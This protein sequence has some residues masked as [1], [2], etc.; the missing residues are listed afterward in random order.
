MKNIPIPSRPC[1]VVCLLPVPINTIKDGIVYLF[2]AVDVES[3]FVFGADAERGDDI[4]YLLKHIQRLMNNSDFN[5]HSG[6]PFTLVLH[7]YEEYRSQ[8]EALIKPKDGTL[9][10]DSMYVAEIMAPVIES[11]AKSL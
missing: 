5:R 2:M 1:E 10:F 6:Q 4:E 11:F 8:I 9:V 7:Q 3:E